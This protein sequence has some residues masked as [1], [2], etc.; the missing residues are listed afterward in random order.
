MKSKALTEKTL[1]NEIS[2]LIEQ[3][4]LQLV[5]QAK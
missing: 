2:Q 4:Q 1:F 3:S 5:A